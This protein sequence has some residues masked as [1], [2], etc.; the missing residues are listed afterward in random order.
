M[1][2]CCQNQARLRGVVKSSLPLRAFFNKINQVNNP[3]RR[4]I[5]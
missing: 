4:P 2:V 5:M 1:G 3:L